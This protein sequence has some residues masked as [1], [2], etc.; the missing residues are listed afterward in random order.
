MRRVALQ[1]VLVGALGCSGNGSESAGFRAVPERPGVAETTPAGPTTPR[2]GGL[3]VEERGQG[4]LTIVLLHGYGAPGDDMVPLGEELA[5]AVPARVV[6]PAAPR[7]WM[8]GPPGRAWFE[9]EPS[10]AR[11][12]LPD[13]ARALDGVLRTLA[14]E[15]V[16]A[17]RVVL[18]GFS[19]G[20]MMALERAMRTRVWG[21]GARPAGVVALSGRPLPEMDGGFERL[22]GVPV[23]VSHGRSDA[24]LPFSDGEEVARRA[25]TAGARVTFVPFEGGHAI[26]EVVRARMVRF[27]LELVEG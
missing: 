4:A 25:G 12:Q 1:V 21:E 9:R 11:Q 22:A 24:I 23:L 15:G 5:R 26:P 10:L 7:T 16:P 18:A 8:G 17:E 27:L 13:A 6:L 20:A 19:Q 2:W 3:S 14:E